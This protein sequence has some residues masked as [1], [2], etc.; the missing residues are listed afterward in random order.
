[1]MASHA[2]ASER[3][4]DACALVIAW[5]ECQCVDV[6]PPRGRLAAEHQLI[7]SPPAFQR[8]R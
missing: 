5:L 7:A 6:V 4:H 2:I 1:M 3:R 8:T